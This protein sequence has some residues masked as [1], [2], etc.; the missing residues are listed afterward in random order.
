VINTLQDTYEGITYALARAKVSQLFA[1]VLKRGS[2]DPP[3]KVTSN[4][5]D[6]DSAYT[7][8]FGKGS[9]ILDLDP[10]DEANFLE[11]SQPSDQ[12]QDFMSVMIALCLKALDIPYSFFAENFTNYSGSRQALLLYEQSAKVKRA[13]V[14]I[15]LNSL[16]K[17]RLEMWIMD[18]VLVLP[19]GMTV[20]DLSWEW[21]PAG[22]PW[23]DPLREVSADAIA[24]ASAQTSRQRLMKRR[25]DDFWEVLDELETEN[26]AL[27]DRGIELYQPAARKRT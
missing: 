9:I 19:S 4:E 20:S 2:A 16:L 8:D 10:A 3:G 11:S 13:E 15:L 7:I 5:D 12:F 26:K 1:L 14:K 22:I 25:G 6:N 18:G 24:I 17:W 27:A 21:Q 23:I